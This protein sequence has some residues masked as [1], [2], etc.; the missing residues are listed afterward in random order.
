M[1]TTANELHREAI[2]CFNQSVELSLKS[3][4]S[5]DPLTADAY[6]NAADILLQKGSRI[7]KSLH[8]GVFFSL[9]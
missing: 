5:I 7:R 1:K 8:N 4:G 9:N 6:I 3:M 2:R